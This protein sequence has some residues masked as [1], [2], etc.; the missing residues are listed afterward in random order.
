MSKKAWGVVRKGLMRGV[1]LVLPPRCVLSGEIVTIPGTL[2]PGA[3]E[4]LR[5]LGEPLCPTCSYPFDFKV[6]DGIQCGFCLADPPPFASARAVLVYD[7]ASR[8]LILRFKHGDQ[9]HAVT[10][11]V[12]MMARAGAAA[13]AGCDL[14]VPVPLHR[15]RLLKRRYNQAALL[16]IGLGR[17]TG[18]PC[19][20]DMLVRTRAT[21]PQ[22]YKKARDRAANVRRAF[23]V[24]GRHAARVAGATVLL[25]DDVYTTGATLRECTDV[26]LRGGAAAVHVLTIARVVRR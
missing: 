6:D 4:S 1:D 23:A 21:P 8:D 20:P 3:W 14:I 2:S 16:A 22:G 17:A 19:V 11:L 13:I 25:V 15:W 24:D 10:A 7:D 12:P 18:K 26:L 5:F 9:L